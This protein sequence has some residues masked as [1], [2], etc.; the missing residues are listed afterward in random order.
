MVLNGGAPF[1]A[2]AQ[3]A[4]GQLSQPAQ[5]TGQAAAAG[6]TPSTGKITF[7]AAARVNKLPGLDSIAAAAP[8]FGATGFGSL[9]GQSNSAF[10]SNAFGSTAFGTSAFGK[11]AA[12]SSNGA[13]PQQ[14]F[15]AAVAAL[16][17]KQPLDTQPK[18]SNPFGRLGNAEATPSAAGNSARFP[19]QGFGTLPPGFDIKP[20]GSASQPA[21]FG[22]PASTAS[23]FGVANAGSNPFASA[24]NESSKGIAFGRALNLASQQQQQTP[25]PAGFS[26]QQA[27]QQASKQKQTA[28]SPASSAELLDPTALAARNTRFGAKQAQGNNPGAGPSAAVGPSPAIQLRLGTP[29]VASKQKQSRS[30]TP[31]QDARSTGMFFITQSDSACGGC[32]IAGR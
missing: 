20:A 7:G 18:P 12:G 17:P 28:Q 29:T 15:G 10:G 9:A 2:P 23:A 19:A 27:K 31:P 16:G 26:A 3:P 8:A 30:R 1:G 22:K 11:S 32:C 14:G 21:P 13:A 24:A 25:L 6:T 5:P 4:F